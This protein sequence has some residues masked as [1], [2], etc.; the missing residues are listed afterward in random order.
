MFTELIQSTLVRLCTEHVPYDS[1]LELDGL[2]CIS[3]DASGARQ[4]VVKIHKVI[5]SSAVQSENERVVKCAPK[6]ASYAEPYSIPSNTSLQLVEVPAVNGIS[7]SITARNVAENIPVVEVTPS[8]KGCDGRMQAWKQRA[9]QILKLLTKSELSPVSRNQ[10]LVPTDLSRSATNG[11]KGHIVTNATKKELPDDKV[12]DLTTGTMHSGNR[13]R[14]KICHIHCTNFSELELHMRSEHVR[15]VCRLCLNSFTLSCNLRRHMKLHA[16]VRPHICS[17][18][19]ATFSRSTDLKIHMKKH[20]DLRSDK[21]QDDTRSPGLET[22]SNQVKSS[23]PTN[24]AGIL[25]ECDICHKG[26]AIASH[27]AD[28][29]Q[30]HGILTVKQ[31]TT[32]NSDGAT[33]SSALKEGEDKSTNSEDISGLQ[34]APDSDSQTLDLSNAAGQNDAANNENAMDYSV[35]LSVK[36]PTCVADL[37]STMRE[38]VPLFDLSEA[39]G[40]DCIEQ[41]GGL[42]NYT[43][44]D[45]L[46][47]L[48]STSKT[49]PSRSKRKGM[50][51]KRVD[52]SSD[53]N[54]DI[55]TDDSGAIVHDVFSV[56][57]DTTGQESTPSPARAESHSPAQ[58]MPNDEEE[59]S[60]QAN[61]DVDSKVYNC[62]YA[63]GCNTTWCGFAAYERHYTAAHGGRYPC[64][65]CPQSFTSRNNRRRHADGHAGSPGSSR[66]QCTA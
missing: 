46:V 29:R 4:I 8:G 20:L 37:D 14:C 47:N 11:I 5:G 52:I 27:L 57:D 13:W 65:V 6:T 45:G 58:S 31:E 43:A 35:N 55:S 41:T 23:T 34:F 61:S 56:G 19:S 17:H 48:S 28:H 30:T 51:V 49:V 38:F 66:H 39:N 12:E 40:M 26:F 50:P 3:S 9:P 16:G 18:C 36:I 33:E 22:P 25:H 7:R 63:G 2:I 10:L 59:S 60:G 42:V 64:P 62:Q 32:K 54:D 24:K 44:S 53:D 1:H 21:G 15:F